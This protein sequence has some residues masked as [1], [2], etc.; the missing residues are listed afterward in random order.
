I[1]GMMLSAE[2][3]EPVAV[4]TIAEAKEAMKT[5]P[6]QVVLSDLKLDREDGVTLLRWIRDEAFPTPVIILTAHGTVDSAVDAMK[7]GAFDYLS[8]P[9]ERSELIRVLNKAVLTYT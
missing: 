8:K 7:Q 2:G 1:L 9:F 6:I 4:R 3:Y 5:Q